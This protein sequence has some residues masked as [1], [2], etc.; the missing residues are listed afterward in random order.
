MLRRRLFRRDDLRMRTAAA[1]ALS[2]RNCS[3]RVPPM[4]TTE[5]KPQKYRALIFAKIAAALL[6]PSIAQN[7]EE[8]RNFGRPKTRDKERNVKQD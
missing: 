1:A 5:T 6:S 3:K 4:P 8:T 2:K 7:S